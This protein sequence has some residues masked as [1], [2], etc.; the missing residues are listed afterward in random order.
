MRYRLKRVIKE[1]VRDLRKNQTEA[2]AIL[3]QEL[4]NRKLNGKKFLRQYPI[5]FTWEDKEHFFV[6]DFYCHEAGLI[7]ELDGGIHRRQKDYD[8]LR[9]AV[10]QDLG[11]RVVRFKN[12]L[13]LNNLQAAL[14]VIKGYL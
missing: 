10:L 1:T 9:E 14:E 2:E 7:I 12:K 4:R 8:K 3:W 5:V 13:V 6:P 11:L